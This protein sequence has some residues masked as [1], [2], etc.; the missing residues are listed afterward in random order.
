MDDNLLI[1]MLAARLE[2]LRSVDS[3]PG[4]FL[5]YLRACID[6]FEWL[7][8]MRVVFHSRFQLLTVPFVQEISTRVVLCQG[9][10]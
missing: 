10:L 6:P 7:A 8:V 9:R 1:V 3:A 2:C 4:G 5:P